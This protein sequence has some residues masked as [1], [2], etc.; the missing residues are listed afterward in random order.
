MLS[1]NLI[2]AMEGDQIIGRACNAKMLALCLS[3]VPIC[4]G[5]IVC[6]CMYAM[7]VL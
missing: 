6:V 7:H 4:M 2:V 3:S 5:L 1:Q